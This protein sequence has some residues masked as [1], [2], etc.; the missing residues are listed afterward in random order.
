M[1]NEN[2]NLSRKYNSNY[3]Y[4]NS[5]QIAEE[6]TESNQNAS[7]TYESAV[8][9]PYSFKEPMRNFNKP[10]FMW[11]KGRCLYGSKCRFFHQD[12]A[13]HPKVIIS[14]KPSERDLCEM[15]VLFDLL[16]KGI[17]EQV[18]NYT[19]LENIEHFLYLI[20]CLD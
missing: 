9:S 6:S 14:D 11:L 19:I 17:I 20:D 2:F 15:D 18:F 5:S 4:S 3:E 10:C 12:Y 1:N 13:N 8:N 7:T 16:N